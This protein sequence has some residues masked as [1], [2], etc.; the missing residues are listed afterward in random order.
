[1]AASETPFTTIANLAAVL[2]GT[3]KR[4]EKRRLIAD[5]LRSVRPDEIPAAVLLT[6]GKIFPEREQRALNVG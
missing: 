6:V 2:A 4:L 1:M 5:Y 3:T